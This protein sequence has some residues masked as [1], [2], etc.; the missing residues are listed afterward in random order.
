VATTT[1]IEL[2]RHYGELSEQETEEL[3]EAVAGL[4]V[5]F[6]KRRGVPARPPQET[7]ELFQE[8]ER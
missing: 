4:V 8:V 2:T 5:E 6:I 7:Q 1:P 3:V